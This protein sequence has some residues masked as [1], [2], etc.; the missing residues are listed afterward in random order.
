LLVPDHLGRAA[1]ERL[2]VVGHETSQG[3]VELRGEPA[4][5]VAEVRIRAGRRL[6]DLGQHPPVVVSRVCSKERAGSYQYS[7]A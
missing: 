4:W 6:D 7:V 1:C 3:R 5:I 2:A